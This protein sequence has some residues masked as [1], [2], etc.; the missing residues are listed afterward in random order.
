MLV[1]PGGCGGGLCW[2]YYKRVLLFKKKSSLP[3]RQT[4]SIENNGYFGASPKLGRSSFPHG[5]KFGAA[6]SAYQVEGAAHEGGKGPSIWDTFSH[7]P[8]KI[9]DGKN[10]DIAVDQY[11][12]YK[13]DVQLL[14]YMGMD[15]Y[16]FSIS[17][18]RIFPK[19]SPRHGGVNEEGIAYYNNLINELLKNGIQ[20]FVTLFHWDLPQALEDEYG[21][22]RSKRVVADFSFFADQCFRAF[23]DRVKYWLTINEPLAFSVYGYDLG[24]L[25]PGRCSPPFGNCTSGNSATEPYIVAHNLL[26]AHSAAVKIYRTKYQ[27]KQKGSIGIALVMSWVVPY[28]KKSLADQQAA[29]RAIDFRIGWYLDPLTSGKYPDSMRRL[30]G[31][32]LPRFSRE[33]AKDLRGSFDFLGYN[34]YFTQLAINNP[35]PPNPL[36]T[37]YFLDARANVTFE[38]NGDVIGSNEGISAFRSYPKGIRDLINYTKHR[39]NNPPIYITETGYADF[40]NGTTPLK[41]A[42]QDSKRVKYH[43]QHLSNLLEAIR[44]GADVRGYIVWALLDNFEWFNGY[45][46]RFGLNYVDYRHNLKRYA[47]ASAYWFKHLLRI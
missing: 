8:G 14:K 4:L 32:R 20:P 24:L 15:V 28:S 43:Y 16:R 31:A 44:E 35:N 5:F 46:V 1:V 36:H 37:D 13:E 47:K 34:Y 6:T 17:W 10:G 40:D 30:V 12:R 23:G 18:P 3:N 26:L 19:G 33:E 38:I 11:H 9:A 45:N 42:L 2:D 41:K 7:I 29:Q 22:F 21:G 27:A 25:A 39:Y